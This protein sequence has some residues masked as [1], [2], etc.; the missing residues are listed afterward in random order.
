MAKVSQ[1][2][3]ALA[4]FRKSNKDGDIRK[5]AQKVAD[6]KKDTLTRLKHLRTVL[7]ES[8]DARLL[9]I[10]SPPI[11]F[12]S[13]TRHLH[14]YLC[15]LET[16]NLSPVTY[17]FDLYRC[18]IINEVVFCS[19]FVSISSYHLHQNCKHLTCPAHSKSACGCGI[20]AVCAFV[21]IGFSMQITSYSYS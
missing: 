17:L 14:S 15:F 10:Q 12:S 3:S 13:Q 11:S 6:P 18:L 16:F 1:M 9:R 2:S 8:G 20:F 4:K 7:G 5:A 19:L 21:F